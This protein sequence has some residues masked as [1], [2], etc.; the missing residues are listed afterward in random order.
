MAGRPVDP[1]DLDQL[2]AETEGYSGADLA[3]MCA[4]ATRSAL[5]NAAATGQLGPVTMADLDAA[6]RQVKPTTGEWL[7]TARNA[8]I[9]ANHDGT[10]DDLDEF[11]K[12]RRC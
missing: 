7:T 2:A 3:H 9:F 4:V 11:L 6:R 12:R 5:G 8:A 10:Y 1:L